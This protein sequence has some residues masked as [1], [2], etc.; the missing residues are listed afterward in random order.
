MGMPSFPDISDQELEALQ[1]F[2]RLRAKETLP[3]YDM[4]TT[5]T[6]IEDEVAKEEMGH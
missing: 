1:H 5:E 4:L 3:V 2:I 6:N